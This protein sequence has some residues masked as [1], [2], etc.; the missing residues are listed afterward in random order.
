MDMQANSLVDFDR[1]AALGNSAPVDD[2][3]VGF[4]VL[5]TCPLIFWLLDGTVAGFASAL[6]ILGLF[7]VGLVCLSVGQKNHLA[8]DAAE[9]AARPKIP[10]KLIGSCIVA[11]VVA[12][13]AT[14]KIDVP[15]IPVVIG[16]STFILC[17]VS[18]GLDP[19]RD[20]GMEDPAVHIRLQNQEIYNGFEDRFDRLL[21]SLSALKDDD[22][23]E[24]T[25]GVADTVMGLLGTINFES[26]KLQKIQPSVSKMLS[27]MEADAAILTAGA[28]GKASAF[29]RRK[30]TSKTQAMVD[31][32]EARAR[33]SGIAQGRDNF[34]LQTNLLFER[35]NRKRLG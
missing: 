22:L 23:T 35:M 15:F 6:L 31:A 30:F 8:Y 13:L 12:L 34:E 20:K 9:V 28:S 1:S 18:F 29:E 32:F 21:L 27:K 11:L 25:R 10:M 3:P 19:V 2:V 14:T 17:L 16:F 26:T 33:K 5:A 4:M 24:R 7:A